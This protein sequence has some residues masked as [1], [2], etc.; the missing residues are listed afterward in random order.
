M[1]RGTRIHSGTGGGGGDKDQK[2]NFL[3]SFGYDF[4]LFASDWPAMAREYEKARVFLTLNGTIDNVDID[5]Y[6]NRMN[7]AENY[8]EVSATEKVDF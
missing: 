6:V 8:L 3:Q 5:T 1:W 4:R 2:T 7:P